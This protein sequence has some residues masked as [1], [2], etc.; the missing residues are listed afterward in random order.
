MITTAEDLLADCSRNR[1]GTAEADCLEPECVEF[2]LRFAL[3][4]LLGS[5][6][7]EREKSEGGAIAARTLAAMIL[8]AR[9]VAAARLL[10]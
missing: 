2:M 9:D 10:Q 5:I 4:H 1:T 3:D 8:S 6:D 7:Y